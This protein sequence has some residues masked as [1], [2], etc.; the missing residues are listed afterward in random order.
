[1]S[2]NDVK[3]LGFYSAVL[4]AVLTALF[5]LTLALGLPL[6]LSFLICLLLAPAFVAMM[7]SLHY[8]APPAKQVWSHLGVC[9]AVLYAAMITLTYYVQLTAVRLGGS[10][11]ALAQFVYKPGTVWFAV[12]M[13]GY[14]FMTL[15]TW[16]AAPVFTGG[17]RLSVWLK[18][19]YIL[20]GVMV[21]PTLIAPALM[22]PSVGESADTA[23]TYALLGWVA[24][25]IPL[26][27][28]TARHFRRDLRS[29]A[30]TAG[31]S[32]YGRGG[33]DLRIS[34]R[35]ADDQED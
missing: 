30:G 26:A 1:M 3:Q 15:A 8:Q 12:D 23:G 18:R 19:F 32:L 27:V 33:A 4:V 9:F 29:K 24:I 16:F 20:H 28:M 10:D 11:G 17:N 6:M 2:S 21:V 31:H 34:A 22:G 7:V 5:G 14:A 35:Y 25:F 13:L